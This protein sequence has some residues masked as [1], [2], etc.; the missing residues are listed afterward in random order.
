MGREKTKKRT[1]FIIKFLISILS[2]VLFLSA[3]VA[4]AGIFVYKNQ[5]FH[6]YHY[7]ELF[8]AF[9]EEEC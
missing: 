2:F 9:Q 1:P 4:F 6:V 7:I 5:I 3:I 8:N